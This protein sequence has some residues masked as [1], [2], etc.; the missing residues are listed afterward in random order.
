MTYKTNLTCRK[1]SLAAAFMLLCLIC[2]SQYNFALVDQL[3]LDNQKALGKELA[4]LIYKDGKIIYQ[5]ETGDFTIKTR[6]PIASCSKWLTAALVM[7]FVDEGKITIDLFTCSLIVENDK[8]K[9]IIKD[10][11]EVNTFNI[12]ASYFTRGS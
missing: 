7:T 11:F 9:N 12:D 4:V 5:K 8:I 3:L 10:Y 1:F 2:K 6:A